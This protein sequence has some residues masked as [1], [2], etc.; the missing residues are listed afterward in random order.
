MT[1]SSS[2]D[3][4]SHEGSTRI[5]GYLEVDEHWRPIKFLQA[6]YQDMCHEVEKSTHPFWCWSK[7]S[8]TPSDAG[9]QVPPSP[10]CLESLPF[11]AVV[12]WYEV[13]RKAV[14]HM[15]VYDWHSSLTQ[16]QQQKLYDFIM[17]FSDTDSDQST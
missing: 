13:M 5:L 3:Q 1:E 10:V 16:T 2:T 14:D 15:I 12:K 9:E 17:S 6:K 4:N 8:S 11:E 7:D